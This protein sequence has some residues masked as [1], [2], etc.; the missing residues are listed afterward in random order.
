[1]TGMSN[2]AQT[3]RNLTNIA[4]IPETVN[5]PR[6]ITRDRYTFGQYVW[7]SIFLRRCT[8]P[9]NATPKLDPQEHRND[10]ANTR[11][12]SPSEHQEPTLDNKFVPTL[13]AQGAWKICCLMFSITS[14]RPVGEAQIVLI[15]KIIDAAPLMNA[16]SIILEEPFDKFGRLLDN[17]R[18]H[19][20]VT[21]PKKQNQRH[22]CTP[23]PCRQSAFREANWRLPQ[24]VDSTPTPKVREIPNKT[25]ASFMN[26]NSKPARAKAPITTSQ[27][28]T[29]VFVS[30][31]V[32]S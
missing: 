17:W 10:S 12:A 25:S 8:I 3:P 15:N 1:M 23:A 11:I 32:L 27:N 30:T 19:K 31:L 5:C 18:N 26:I 13:V 14:S 20:T 29:N 7:R 22:V 4:S 24:L 16:W 6:N 21:H 9:I 2:S 28:R